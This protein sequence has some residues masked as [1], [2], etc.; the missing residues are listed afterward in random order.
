MAFCPD[1][2]PETDVSSDARVC[3]Q[4]GREQDSENEG[5]ANS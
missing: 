5:E 1:V 3:Q 4:Q 2:F